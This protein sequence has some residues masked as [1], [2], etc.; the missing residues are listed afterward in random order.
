MQERKISGFILLSITFL[1]IS[2]AAAQTYTSPERLNWQI[3]TNF[4]NK[5][6]NSSYFLGFEGATYAPQHP[7]TPVY[8]QKINV[9]LPGKV[10][11][12]LRNEVY[13]PET[14]PVIINE[15][16]Y[17]PAEPQIQASMQELNYEPLVFVKFVPIRKN[18]ATGQIEKLS[19][20]TI[21]VTVDPDLNGTKPTFS[22]SKRG[23]NSSLLASGDWYK[24]GVSN[25]G[26]YKLDY[27]FLKGLGLADNTDLSKVKIYG[28]PG[29]MLPEKNN[30]PRDNDLVQNAIQV[31][32]SSGKLDPSSYLLFYAKGPTSW[33]Y[34]KTRHTFHHQINYYSDISYYF[35][36]ANGDP[37]NPAKRIQTLTT[38]GTPNNEISGY[39]AYDYHEI[40]RVTALT[41]SVK[42]GREWY[43]EDF[44]AITKLTLPNDVFPG[45][46][47]FD[48]PQADLSKQ[49]YMQTDVAA[50]SYPN[51]SS[52]SFF[53][54]NNSVQAYGVPSVY[55]LDDF[56][57]AYA[58][59][60]ALGSFILTPSTHFNITVKFNPGTPEA[61]GWL[62]YIELNVPCKLNYMPGQ[63][64]F[65]TGS[66]LGSNLLNRYHLSNTPASFEVW[67]VTD[68]HNVVKINLTNSGADRTFIDS[69]N[70]LREFVGCD[71]TGYYTP[72]AYGK[73]DSQDIHGAPQP[74]MVIVTYPDFK[75]A[76]D[77]IAQYHNF[78]DSLVVQVV[79]PQ[80]VYNE[81]SSGTQD[82]SAIRDMMKMFYEQGNSGG[83]PPRFLLLIGAASYDY[84]DRVKNHTNFIP[85]YQG[86]LSTYAAN[87]FCS[88]DYFTMV[89]PGQGNYIDN[90]DSILLQMCVGRL[91]VYNLQQAM[92][93]YHK[94]TRYN[95][96][97]SMHDW[98]NKVVFV[99]DDRASNDFLYDAENCVGFIAKQKPEMNIKKLYFDATPEVSTSAG[100]L[101]PQINQGIDE[102]ITNGCLFMDYIGHG[103][104]LGWGHEKVLT[105]P[106]I[107]GWNNPYNM[108]LII[109]ATCQFSTFDDPDNVSAGELALFNPT[110][111]PVALLT[112][113]REVESGS[114]AVLDQNILNNNILLK[115]KSTHLA[116]YL[117]QVFK[118]AKN[119]SPNSN[120]LNFTLLGDPAVRLAVPRYDVNVTNI[121]RHNLSSDTFKALSLMT[122]SGEV[123]KDGQIIADFNGD[124][125][126]TVFDKV[127][128]KLTLGQAAGDPADADSPY[129]FSTQET[130]IYKGHAAVLK[131]KFTFQF[132]VP[133]D[134]S[135]SYGLGKLS[136]YAANGKIDA[137]GFNDSIV[138]GGSDEN[139]QVSQSP[140]KV[141]LFIND[142]NFVN[143]GM[144][145]E[146][147]VLLALVKSEV[148]INTLGSV[149]HDL[150]AFLTRTDNNAD[151]QAPVILNNFYSADKGS[152]QS[153]SISY[154]Y[155]GLADGKYQLSVKVWD[156]ANNPAEA[157]TDFV[158]VSS[159]NLT[160]DKIFN[161]PNP[162]VDQTTFQFEDNRPNETL[163]VDIS[164]FDL[165]GQKV[166]DIQ[167]DLS[168]GGSRHTEVHW[169][170]TGDG[171]SKLSAG[172]YVYQLTVRS[173]DG[174]V[175]QK[176]QK[177][178]LIK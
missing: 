103:G 141:R 78:H 111:G 7:V 42:S 54:N 39:D 76:A 90:G 138:V 72:G 2:H 169:D 19:S 58:E 20:F 110:G 63:F 174:Q 94:I 41:T 109:S 22:A 10:T 36:T 165:R 160:I 75:A 104:Q 84:K 126:P 6:I 167:A 158:V 130:I 133:K 32:S 8:S 124:V 64:G 135:F 15:L 86:Y 153:G 35:L 168:G 164:I 114:N 112:T 81:F 178:V 144:T 25:T 40:D 18:A 44:D 56:T 52:F 21:S 119:A 93:I 11:A 127:Q 23:S 73:V 53:I 113:T 105:I 16:N 77:S 34:D 162:L 101:F 82:V 37:A 49:L 129:S 57:Y 87:S 85:T 172:M 45:T 120:N 159:K 88:D 177:L 38:S 79:T 96:P 173:S 71:G 62:N 122:I 150:Q 139:A 117:G 1:Y 67:E 74:D 175:A 59:T 28:R 171:G 3:I 26:I 157:T 13:V 140:P 5:K 145:N 51:G 61:L 132:V 106:M 27:N 80:Q 97:K 154:P 100:Q 9:A 68:F 99:A 156:V 149:G 161:Y 4:S 89:A 30:I 102:N 55:S 70:V 146:N 118:D 14:D 65:R 17:L 43:G 128:K 134:I 92:D 125:Y 131:G 47:A 121:S 137:I 163:N 31:V 166:K 46:L 170:G 48:F 107:N 148:G 12:I 24:I 91:P 123:D 29:G 69:G 152:Y 142:T 95:D 66:S 143:G 50:R 136:L 108:P 155:K 60:N 115:D 98:R 176:S 33:S 116:K 151:N 147:P 83:H